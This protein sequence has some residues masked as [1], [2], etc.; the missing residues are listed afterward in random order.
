MSDTED[1]TS[2]KEMICFIK[3]GSARIELKS[4]LETGKE[5]LWTRYSNEVDTKEA[6]Q[7]DQ[8]FKMIAADPVY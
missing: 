8:N 1:E 7:K 5:K 2:F 4:Q 3:L 6:I